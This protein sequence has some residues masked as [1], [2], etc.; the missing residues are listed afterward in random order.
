MLCTFQTMTEY[1][2]N[3]FPEPTCCQAKDATAIITC[4]RRRVSTGPTFTW[5]SNLPQLVRD[6]TN[7]R[8]AGSWSFVYSTDLSNVSP[9]KHQEWQGQKAFRAAFRIWA[10]ERT[11]LRIMHFRKQSTMSG[12]ESWLECQNIWDVP[13]WFTLRHKVRQLIIF[14]SHF[15]TWKMRIIMFS[16]FQW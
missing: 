4:S 10:C 2:I 12:R 16:S 13:H 14:V 7:T 8:A 15:L 1:T 3:C 11:S 9:K 6:G 5:W